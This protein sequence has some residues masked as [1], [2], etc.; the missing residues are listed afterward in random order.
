[1]STGSRGLPPVTSVSRI[2]TMPLLPLLPARTSHAR[3]RLSSA[4]AD[5]CTDF[6]QRLV[7]TPSP[8]G[9]EADVAR[10]VADEMRALGFRDVRID[11]VG[12]VVGWLG[13]KQGP[14]LLVDG[15]LDTAAVGDPTAWEVDP[16]GGE[17][18]EG[19]L[20]GLGS[21]DAK[22]SLAA[23]IYGL[24]LLARSNDALP[25]QILVVAV[26]QEEPAEGLAL[27]AALNALDL[28]PDWTLI[29]KPTEMRLVRGHRGRMEVRLSTFGRTAHSAMPEQGDN[30]LYAAARL[31]FGIEL[32]GMNLMKDP[33]LGQGTIAITRFTTHSSAHNAIPDRCDLTIDR[34]ITLGETAS[35]VLA[36]LDTLIQREGVRAQARIAHYQQN[37]YTGYKL[38]ADAHYPAWLLPEDH[39]LLVQAV[40]SMERSLGHKPEVGIWRFS[41]DGVYTVGLA[42]IPTIGFGP[43]RSLLSHA[44][45]ESIQLAE[46]HRS[47]PLYADLARDLLFGLSNLKR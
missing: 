22:G 14:I 12:N 23:M 10:L 33:V 31:V 36:E 9:Q 40:A 11:D 41:S 27:Q 37:S 5:A 19:R 13:A 32:L 29:A 39:P 46:V 21:V 26:V 3:E 38:A 24:G 20:Y 7:S 45:N 1:M 44:P 43:G 16:F 47:I 4:Y 28:L 8:S 34:R 30:A 6:L 2:K 25:G 17:I 42:G 35:R 15:H 18:R